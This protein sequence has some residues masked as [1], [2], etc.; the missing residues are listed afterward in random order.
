MIDR[1]REKNV[2]LSVFFPMRYSP[3]IVGA[4]EFIRAGGLGE[5]IGTQILMLR[6]KSEGCAQ[7]NTWCEV[8]PSWRN[9]RN[10]CGGGILINLMTHYLDYFRFLTG[11]EVEEV[12]GLN[13][14]RL[15]PI[16]V[17]DTI[18]VMYRY[19]NG[20]QGIVTSSSAVR[21]SGTEDNSAVNNTLQNIWGSDGQLILYPRLKLFSRKRAVGRPPN[22]WHNTRLTPSADLRPRTEFIERFSRAVIEGREP[23][24]TGEDGLQNLAIVEAAY[25]SSEEKRW[26][27]IKEILEKADP[28]LFKGEQS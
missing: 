7:R 19:R 14:T 3:A 6:D 17:E 5:L 2:A 22:R 11:L 8:T 23:E 16:D 27:S 15:L 4:A 20:A 10:K 1:C 21:G 12:M 13:S 26:V 25:L 28:K 18:T 9:D 24:V